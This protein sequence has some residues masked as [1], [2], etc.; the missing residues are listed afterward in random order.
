MEVWR[1]CLQR[2]D[3]LAVAVTLNFGESPAAI[4]HSV[5]VGGMLDQVRLWNYGS[6]SSGFGD[7][8]YMTEAYAEAA[9]V[10][11]GGV[12]ETTLA[13]FFKVRDVAA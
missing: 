5:S 1:P 3:G 9:V 2:G 8:D 11:L 12:V 13:L 10:V 6:I 4:A 7:W